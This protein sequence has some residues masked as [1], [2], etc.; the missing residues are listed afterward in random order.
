MKKVLG[1]IGSPRKKGN[2]HQL[3]SRILEG[4]RSAGA[5][6]ELV[7]LDDLTIREC[8]GCNICWGGKSCSRSDD[9]T[10]C[11]RKSLHPAHWSSER[12]CIGTAPRR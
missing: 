1:I 4:A 9:M 7:L 6:T 11:M 3:V 5:D 12:R 10:G 2:T 8:I